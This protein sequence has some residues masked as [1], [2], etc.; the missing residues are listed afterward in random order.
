MS[1]LKQQ[2]NDYVVHVVERVA[3]EDIVDPVLVGSPPGR[4]EDRPL[5]K[6][7]PRWWPAVAAA[8]AVLLVVGMIGL[9]TGN[10]DDVS[11]QPPRTLNP[12]INDPEVRNPQGDFLLGRHTLT[13]EGVSFSVDVSAMGWEPWS[14]DGG[15]WLISKSTHGPQDAEAVIF[16]A[17]FPD[18]TYADPCE[19][20]DW[21][22]T[23]GSTAAALWANAVSRA[24][25]TQ[26]VSGPSEVTIGG[27]TAHH[28]VVRVAEDVGC[29]PG[30]FYNWKAQTGG[31]L[32]VRSELGD[33]IRVW[34]VDVDGKRLFIA[35]ETRAIGTGSIIDQEI[36]SI[37]ES[38]RFD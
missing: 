19:I 25:G 21:T 24:P 37:V 15:T 28:V 13:A 22:L 17:G 20:Y 8:A 7:L 11:D 35:G 32:W 3:I 29:D 31:A 10:R 14:I 18:G 12:S 36:Y 9:L 2:L 16:W 6:G 23:G 30:F 26:L 38:I 5:M 1:E 33:T 4:F 27:L 34:I